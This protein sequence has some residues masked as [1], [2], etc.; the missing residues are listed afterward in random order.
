MIKARV[1]DRFDVWVR[2]ALPFLFRSH[3]HPNLITVAGTLVS[4]G[5]GVAFARGAFGWGGVLIGVGGLFDLV[6]G[7]LARHQGRASAFGAFLDSSLDRLVDIG[8]LV[9]IM[10]FYASRG[11]AGTVLLAGVA[12]AASVLT[13]YTKARAESLVP[14]LSGG[15]FERAE[16]LLVLALGGVTGWLVPALW[17]VAVLGVLTVIQRFSLAYRQMAGLELTERSEAGGHPVP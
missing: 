9:G 12:L 7:V 10:T 5:A 2:R 3:I 16:R 15:F 11:E 13:S 1:G 6:D 17:I 8:I 4:L 14:S